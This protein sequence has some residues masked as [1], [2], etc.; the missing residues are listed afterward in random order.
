MLMSPRNKQTLLDAAIKLWEFANSVQ[1]TT[2]CEDCSFFE[3]GLCNKWNDNVPKE[4][5]QAGCEEFIYDAEKIP[6]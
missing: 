1:T 6:F 5:Q 2:P 4:V 3:L